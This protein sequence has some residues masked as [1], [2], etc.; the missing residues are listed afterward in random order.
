MADSRATTGDTD[1]EQQERFGA[2]NA[3]TTR[4]IP[5]AGRLGIPAE[6]D[7]AILSVIVVAPTGGGYLTIWPCG[8]PKPST[9]SLNF[10]KG[11]TLANTVLTKLGDSGTNDGKVC[12]YTSTK[13][14][15]I[16]DTAGTLASASLQAL[17]APKRMADSRATT[18]DTD[19]EQ[20]ERFGA[21]NAG[22]TR[23]IPIAGRLGIPA[24]ADNAILAVIV[25][26]PTGGGYL[27]I[28]P[29]GQPKPST[30]SLNFTKG[31]TLA[32]TVLTKLGD[33]GTNDGKV[34]VYT[35]TKTDIVIDTAGS[36]L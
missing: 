4:A 26:A 16:I 14:D 35:S 20:Q 1:D 27:T 11:V 18:G 25:V 12:V 2:L 15:I 9:S 29:C 10:T 8:Q 7:N 5:I 3:G 32:N 33:S 24:E 30:S 28:W 13:T 6:A 19:D 17:P 22:T 36:I 21:L 23:A 34:C 31:V